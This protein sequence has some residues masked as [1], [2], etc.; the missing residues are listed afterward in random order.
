MRTVRGV[1]N[2]VFIPH[3]SV[4]TGLGLS[5]VSLAVLIYFIHHVSQSIQ[6]PRIIARISEDLIEAIDD[7]FPD[8]FGKEADPPN[9]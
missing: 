4:L 1:E 9:D 8:Q 7:L 6:A 3:I 5:I 2:S